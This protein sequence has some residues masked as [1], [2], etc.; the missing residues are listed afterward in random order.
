M[1]EVWFKGK[2]ILIVS[3]VN[4]MMQDNI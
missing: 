1:M 3:S 4:G 2:V